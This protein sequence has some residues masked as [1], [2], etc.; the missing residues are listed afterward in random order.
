MVAGRLGWAELG[1]RNALLQETWLIASHAVA[2]H[3]DIELQRL[4]SIEFRNR[5]D[6]NS[7][8]KIVA[9][10]MP[11]RPDHPRQIIHKS[12]IMPRMPSKCP[13]VSILGRDFTQPSME[14]AKYALRLVVSTGV[15]LLLR[16]VEN[17]SPPSAIFHGLGPRWC[18]DS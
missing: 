17:P 1:A 12:E 16:S 9:M 5:T 13:R 2:A 6:A 3:K 14:Y 8:K 11:R 4:C 10:P 7:V 18:L 15:E